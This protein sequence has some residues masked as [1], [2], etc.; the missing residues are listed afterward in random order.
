[1]ETRE[2]VF[3]KDDE[4]SFHSDSEY[5]SAMQETGDLVLRGHGVIFLSSH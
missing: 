3:A 5:C 2:A 1:M 4:L